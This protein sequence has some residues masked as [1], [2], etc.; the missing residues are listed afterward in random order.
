MLKNRIQNIIYNETE[1][2]Y[3]DFRNLREDDLIE[4]MK[5]VDNFVVE[6]GKKNLLKLND[7]RG[8][9]T[10]TSILSEIK[11]SSK[12]QNPYIKKSAYLGIVGVKKI[13]LAAINRVSSIGAK[14]FTEFDEAQKWLAE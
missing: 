2:L 5:L 3:I 1:I 12:L 14:A 9:Y 11:R 8:Q 10:S 6:T 7:V 13:L 4:L